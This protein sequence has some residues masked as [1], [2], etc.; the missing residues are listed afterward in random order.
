MRDE[1]EARATRLIAF[2]EA[3]EKPV[4]PT[5]RDI[6]TALGISDGQVGYMLKLL[7]HRGVIAL[8][9]GAIT[10]RDGRHMPF[11]AAGCSRP[12]DIGVVPDGSAGVLY[13]WIA[14]HADNSWID[15]EIIRQN[16]ADFDLLLERECLVRVPWPRGWRL[17]LLNGRKMFLAG[18]RRAPAGDAVV[19]IVRTIRDEGNAPDILMPWDAPDLAEASSNIDRLAERMGVPRAAVIQRAIVLGIKALRA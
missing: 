10:L 5:R 19:D 2:I 6:S 9:K 16:D 1:I 3:W 8:D 15:P 4:A 7:M 14:G 13:A 12:R 17:Q 11:F 18:A